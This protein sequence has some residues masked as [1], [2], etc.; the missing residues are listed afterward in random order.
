MVDVCL[1]R[2]S[3]EDR[4]GGGGAHQLHN[5]I[6]DHSVPMIMSKL[7]KV[8]E[9]YITYFGLRAAEATIR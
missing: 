7:I 9:K 2:S 3:R 4:I 8:Y 1:S 5:L 6:E